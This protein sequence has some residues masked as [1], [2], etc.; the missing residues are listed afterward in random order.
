[1]GIGTTD[2]HTIVLPVPVCTTTS[3]TLSCHPHPSSR[4]PCCSRPQPQYNLS[5]LKLGLRRQLLLLQLL[6]QRIR[7]LLA[8][9]LWLQLRL[10]GQSGAAVRR[11]LAQQ[12]RLSPL[13]A[14]KLP[15]DQLWGVT[16]Y[17][18]AW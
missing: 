11:L 12:R 13:D 3:D 6:L 9:D 5:L 16:R 17:T 10:R 1:M 4:L 8:A 7:R 15:A 14:R 18:V 2:L